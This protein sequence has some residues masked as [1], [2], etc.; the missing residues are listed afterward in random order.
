MFRELFVSLQRLNN[1]RATGSRCPK[2]AI[3]MSGD[4]LVKDTA[5]TASWIRK[6]PRS[7]AR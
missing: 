3:F 4:L 2:A 7:L 1:H 5:V 6:R